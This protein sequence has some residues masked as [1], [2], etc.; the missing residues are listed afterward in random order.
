MIDVV[1]VHDLFLVHGRGHDCAVNWVPIDEMADDG[2]VD[3]VPPEMAVVT[4]LLHVHL[5]AYLRTVHCLEHSSDAGPGTCN[6]Y[7]K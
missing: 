5:L 2:L 3:V 4:L 7:Y 1:G 6:T